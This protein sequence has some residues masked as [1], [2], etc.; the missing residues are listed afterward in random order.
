MGKQHSMETIRSP[1]AIPGVT[2]S[3]YSPPDPD[4]IKI[5]ADYFSLSIEEI[6]SKTRKET[7]RLPRQIAMWLYKKYTKLS[8]SQI[9]KLCGD[10]DHATV[11]H[12]FKAV[13]DMIDSNYKTVR[14]NVYKLEQLIK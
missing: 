12:S 5:T 3:F 7:I 10:K 13:N 11:C 14:D 4:I 6:R 1:Y 9:G 8:L 2:H